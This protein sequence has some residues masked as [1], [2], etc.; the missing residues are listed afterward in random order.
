VARH[1]S[2]LRIPLA[3]TWTALSATA[4]SASSSCGSQRGTPLASVDGTAGEGESPETDAAV[5]DSCPVSRGKG[6][7]PPA[8]CTGFVDG[9]IEIFTADAPYCPDGFTIV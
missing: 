7:C 1:G 8:E 9:A 4:I 5:E 2:I 6:T 3:L